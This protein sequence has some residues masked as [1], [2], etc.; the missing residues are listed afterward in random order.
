[1]MLIIPKPVLKFFLLLIRNLQFHVNTM[2]AFTTALVFLL[3]SESKLLLN[4]VTQ[5]IKYS[6]NIILTLCLSSSK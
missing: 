1:M 3:V 2:L 6:R 5:S 4:I